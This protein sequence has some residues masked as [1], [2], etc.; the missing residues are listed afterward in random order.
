MYT[1]TVSTAEKRTVNK[2]AYIRNITLL[3]EI[4]NGLGVY[5]PTSLPRSKINACL[6]GRNQDFAKG[7]VT[8]MTP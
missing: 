4:L 5:M 7:G 3:T 2:S 8:K 6:Q 1:D